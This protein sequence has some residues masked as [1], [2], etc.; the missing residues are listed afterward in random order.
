MASCI[1]YVLEEGMG[2]F[3]SYGKSCPSARLL[4][5]VL[6]PYAL[7]PLVLYEHPRQQLLDP[8]EYSENE[9]AQSG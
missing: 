8:R 6:D 4:R 1:G 7:G 3:M 5:I 9:L 2:D